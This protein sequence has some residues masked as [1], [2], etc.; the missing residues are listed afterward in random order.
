MRTQ[1]DRAARPAK[2]EEE[3][4]REKERIQKEGLS[5]SIFHEAEAREPSRSW[6]G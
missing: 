6:A 2:R 5:A 4:A 1:M 3:Q